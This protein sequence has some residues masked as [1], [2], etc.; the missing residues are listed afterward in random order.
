MLSLP[1]RKA[2]LVHR[3]TFIHRKVYL[4]G[5]PRPSDIDKFLEY[6]EFGYARQVSSNELK[7]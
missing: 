6:V 2:Y 3:P 7:N 1:W 5:G 4:M